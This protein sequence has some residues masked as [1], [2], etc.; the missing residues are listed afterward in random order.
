[1]TINNN[2]TGSSAANRIGTQ[3]GGNVTFRTGKSVVVLIYDGI[4]HG[5]TL[6]GAWDSTGA[7]IG[8][9]TT[10]TLSNKTLS[11]PIV[12]SSLRLGLS[13]QGTC[14]MSSGTCGAINLASAYTNAPV[15]FISWTG[16]G[17]L[18]GKLEISATTTQV[19]PASSVSG[20]SAQVGWACF[21]D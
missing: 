5:W 21:G 15:C 17:T 3:T 1:M 8:A 20:D 13:D 19:T 4:D 14:T 11:G 9:A 18:T 10:D 16:S 2:D 6:I 12:P 7:P